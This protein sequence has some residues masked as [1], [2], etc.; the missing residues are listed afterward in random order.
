MIAALTL[1]ALASPI[2]QLGFSSEGAA[3]AG[4]T[5][6]R[7]TG[8]AVAAYHVQNVPKIYNLAPI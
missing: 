7:P 2:D 3:L 1:L 5:Y 6:A 4:A 8:S